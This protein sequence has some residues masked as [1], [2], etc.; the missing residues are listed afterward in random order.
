MSPEGPHSAE[1]PRD[2]GSALPA[3]PV[4]GRT[5]EPGPEPNTFRCP[6]CGRFSGD[7]VNDETVAIPPEEAPPGGG[8]PPVPGVPPRKFAHYEILD[9]IGR[10]GYGVV[11]K[12]RDPHLNRTVALKVLLAAEH[13]SAEEV[14]RFFREAA[15]AAKL[16][17]PNIVPIHEFKTHR[18]KHYYTMAYV[19]GR[20]LDELIAAREL[21]ARASLELIEKVALGLNHAHS[22]GIVHRD[23]K[24]GNILVEADGNPQVADF[25]LAKVLEGEGRLTPSKLTRSGV[26]MGTPQYM[27]P[28]Q[29]CAEHHR[30]DAR[31]DVYSL[32][33]ILYEMLT[34][35]PPFTSDNAMEVLRQHVDDDPVPP[36]AR[37]AKVA[38]DIETI[39]LKCL[40]KDPA[41]RYRSAGELA[42][43]IRRFLDGEPI[44]ARRA[45]IMYVVHR[46]LIRHKAI[47]V[48][49]SGAAALL[50]TMTTWYI[51][52]LR[53]RQ[54][55]IERELYFS[56]VALAHQHV[57]GGNSARADELLA[58]CPPRLRGWE[59]GHVKCAAH[60]EM[61]TLEGHAAALDRVTY[62]PDSRHLVSV[63]EDGRVIVWNARAGEK[64][65]VLEAGS[66]QHAVAVSPDGKLLVSGGADGA[67]T[68][69][70]FPS[71]EKLK[72]ARLHEKAVQDLA[73]SPR[74]DRLV[75]GDRAGWVKLLAAADLRELASFRAHEEGKEFGVECLAISPD[76]ARLAT[77]G[78]GSD[79]RIWDLATR[80]QAARLAGHTAQVV[81][82][83]FGSDG[84]RL[85]S[86][87]YDDLAILWDLETGKPLTRFRGHT[88]A[89]LALDLSP[90]DSRLV[91]TSYDR[92]V[93]LWQVS[94]G[95]PIC[96]LT[97]HLS[98]CRAAAFSPDGKQIATGGVDKTV[99]IWD[100]RGQRSCTFVGELPGIIRSMAFSPDSRSLA[101]GFGEG[102]LQLREIP[103]GREIL[104]VKAAEK[105]SIRSVCFMPGGKSLITGSSDG[106]VR[107]WDLSTGR[108]RRTWQ[109][110]DGRDPLATLSPDGRVLAVGCRGKLIKFYDLNTG[111]LLRSVE[112]NEK[113][114]AALAFSPSGDRLAVADY[115]GGHLRVWQTKTGRPLLSFRAHKGKIHALSFSADGRRLA[116][117]SLDAQVGLWDAAS[118]ESLRI[119]RGHVG[120]VRAVTF[121]PDGTRMAS[122]GM[123]LSVKIWD[124]QAGRELFTLEGHTAK[125]YVV[126]FSPDGKTLVSAGRDKSIRIWR[127]RD[128][129]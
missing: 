68:L 115:A 64:L 49:V 129:R 70:K 5:A 11:Y 81:S 99:R 60:Q 66:R 31:S 95:N 92:T 124:A 33:C 101:V 107:L 24:P 14:E 29:A 88:S 54:R 85:I 122:G 128:W 108:S 75:S 46:K 26:A 20:P 23:L 72:S 42:S 93:R 78:S 4:C 86:G 51:L 91:T 84:R 27:S 100:A 116:S 63:G 16:Q 38:G 106:T 19:R 71:G 103:T 102:S 40:E 121:S 6:D 39:C 52:N 10:G 127:A 118:G 43:D 109:C 34:G 125:L 98:S 111:A 89:V 87:A 82:L 67:V 1:P 119:L 30:I 57:L 105:R 56:N 110:S 35:R 9:E 36:S 7:A 83:V 114:V 117:G 8:P 47:T 76:G 79:V 28:E 96:K 53:D 97:G 21:N 90:D 69:W 45:S 3:C 13:A 59:W 55:H 65:K 77:G 126:L 50:F 17:H 61:L 25:G 120:Q 22:R 123:D 113:G 94:T 62:S 18:G 37:G 80:K 112:G 2:G 32:G 15:S 48:V 44:T 74:G 58:A 73:F 41:R 104:T 12:A